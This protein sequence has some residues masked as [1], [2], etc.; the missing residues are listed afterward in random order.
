MTLVFKH[1]E[2]ICNTVNETFPPK[3]PKES[4]CYKM[5]KFWFSL[6]LA[7]TK[8]R[9][10]LERFC[11]EWEI[12]TEQKRQ[13]YSANYFIIHPMSKLA[14]IYDVYLCLLYFAA[15]FFK[16]MDVAF[17]KRSFM[18]TRYCNLVNAINIIDVLSWC[19]LVCC[20]FQGVITRK[21]STLIDFKGIAL[22][23]LKS[24][25]FWAELLASIPKCLICSRSER[26]SKSVWL[27]LTFMRLF[28]ICLC[29]RPIQLLKQTLGYLKIESRPVLIIVHLFY[30]MA[31]VTHVMTCTSFAMS[32]YRNTFS[33]PSGNSSW[34]LYWNLTEKDIS[35][36][37]GIAF[38]KTSAQTFGI[39]IKELQETMS[40]VDDIISALQY[41][42]G[43]CI[44]II[45]WVAVLHVLLAKDLQETRF[46]EIIS[47]LKNWMENK[48]LPKNL[49]KRVEDYYNFYYRKRF[50]S[51][52]QVQKVIPESLTAK[53]KINMYKT[54]KES[55]IALFSKLSDDEIQ[56]IGEHFVTEIYSPNDVI[57]YS[58]TKG[59][60]LF[61]LASGTVAVYS[62]SGKE[63]C[64]LQDG[65]YFG[66]L[67]LLVSNQKITA[68]IIAIETTKVYRIGKIYFEKYILSKKDLMNMFLS[69]AEK[70]LQ[71]ITKVEEDQKRALFSEMYKTK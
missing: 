67:S 52:R 71:A 24:L 3:K 11:S 10:T 6:T 55:N 63:V 57:I 59:D 31:F 61:L 35:L 7:S 70:R 18:S 20:F 38:L 1:Y 69:Q 21:K 27:L 49:Q 46:Q 22:Y 37:Y 19:N 54:L 5:K 23:R 30:M 56:M 15:V 8:N 36:Q 32:R 42:T 9:L 34:T 12:R 43:R 4:L 58:G 16:L 66:E 29:H 50:F 33:R 51:K 25:Y 48:D 2:H 60:S 17:L 68:T 65:A 44:F 64:H 13:Y 26:C 53:V 41:V 40:W 45:M 47:Q 14:A 62:H 39:T 28:I